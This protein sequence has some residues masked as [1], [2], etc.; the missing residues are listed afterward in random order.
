MDQSRPMAAQRLR[1]AAPP[2]ATATLLTLSAAPLKIWPLA[3]MALVPLFV[4]AAEA[5]TVRRAALYGFAAGTLYFAMNLWWLWTASVPGAIA[6][7]IIFA[8]YWAAVAA[9]VR[10]LHLFPPAELAAPRA[11]ARSTPCRR[12]LALRLLLVA[13]VWVALEWLRCRLFIA[14]PWMPLGATQTPALAMCQVADLGGPWI[15]SFWVA[16]VNALLAAMWICRHRPVQ[17]WPAAATVCLL[18]AATAGYGVWRIATAPQTP[19]PRVMV[20]Q[21]NFATLPGGGATTT[22]ETAVEFY[23]AELRSRLT[24]EPVDLVVLPE[25]AFPPINE[26][27]RRNLAPGAVGPFLQRTH[28]AL[29]EISRKFHVSLLLGGNA[30]TGWSADG[31]ARVGSE[32]RNSAYFYSRATDAE[33][34]RYDKVH[35]VAYCERLPFASGP[36]WLQ[37]LAIAVAANRAAQPMHPGDLA[38]MRPF[39]LPWR[40]PGAER[41]ATARFIAPICLE[42]I[43]PHV[44]AEMLAAASSP[45]GPVDFIANLSSDGWF[46]SQEKHQHLQLVVLR[47]IE[48]RLPMVRSANA[49]VS[50]FIDSTGR[51][52]HAL[53]PDEVG[54]ATWRV[55]LD[56][57]RTLYARVGDAFAIACVAITFAACAVFMTRSRRM[58]RRL[59]P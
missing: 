37:R 33:V 30:V 13:V 36:A 46:A 19:G 58:H 53:P 40:P 27:A 9:L 4:A 22:P 57:R 20:L 16:S 47:S 14:F 35:L 26:E 59:G 55:E 31:Q 38:E 23:L 17:L 56:G 49:G 8:G 1:V 5:A 50:G 32:I 25:A 7:I 52:V 39:R 3:W 21:S 18:L 11:D 43:D 42:N 24:G 29:Q 48:N 44:I 10:G 12:P 2:L 54:S 41:E 45:E 51:V 6:I 15:V 28:E 34:E